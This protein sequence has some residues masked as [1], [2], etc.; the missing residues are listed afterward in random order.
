MADDR[1]LHVVMFPW[2]AQGHIT[3][4]LNLAKS[5]LTSGH[6]ILFFSTLVNIEWIKKKIVPRI[7]LVELQL[8]FVDGLPAGVESMIGL[9]K[10]GRTDLVPLLFQEIDLCEQPF[11]ALLKLLSPDFVI[12]DATLWWTSWVANKMGVPTINFIA[13]DIA[14]MSFAKG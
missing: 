11:G 12:F 1:Q 3:P 14:A 9:S 6:R 2:F 4:F 8:P 13:F 5:I 7:E 10:I